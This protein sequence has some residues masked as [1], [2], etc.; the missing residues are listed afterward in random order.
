LDLHELLF[1]AL[2][3]RAD[4]DSGAVEALAARFPEH[5]EALRAHLRTLESAGLVD[6]D[7]A[8]KDPI[9]ER[10]GAFHLRR[11][12]GQGGMGVVYLADDP[13]LGRQVALK[14][15][16]PEQVHFDSARERFRREALSVARLAH[17][18][19]VPLYTAGAAAGLPYF[20]M[21]LVEGASLADTLRELEGRDPS[22]LTGRDLLVAV[23]AVTARRG[24]SGPPERAGDPLYASTWLHAVL[25][26]V[27][28]VAQALEHAHQRGVLHRDIKPSNVLLTADGRVLL[29]D[30]GLAVL[31][32]VDRLTR[33]GAMLGSLPYMSPEQV[34]GAAAD[35]DGRSD[36]YGLGVLLYELLTLKLPF[37]ESDPT[38]LSLRISRG[39]AA[40]PRQLNRALSS[41]VATVCRTAMEVDRARRYASPADLARDLSNLLEHRP[42]QARASGLGLLLVR[43]AQRRPAHAVGV[44][45]LG[46]A[47]VA[48]P[49]TVAGLERRNSVRVAA[50]RDVASRNLDAALEA[51]EV[52]LERVGHNELRDVPGL[53]RLR[54]TLLTRATDL[55]GRLEATTPGDLRT[56]VR[57]A[58]A[59][60]R[61]ARLHSESGDRPAALAAFDAAEAR[62]RALHAEAPDDPALLFEYGNLLAFATVTRFPAD[63]P[64]AVQA[65]QR[66]V[67]LLRRARALDPEALRPRMELARALLGLAHFLDAQREQQAALKAY[68]E[69]EA[70][71]AALLGE[72]PALGPLWIDAVELECTALGRRG[73]VH[74]RIGE[75]DAALALF[76]RILV[77]CSELPKLSGFMRHLRAAT[78]QTMALAL[79]D[80]SA[81]QGSHP[82]LDELLA[83]AHADAVSLARDFPNN[84]RYVSSLLQSHLGLARRARARKDGAR[85][86]SEVSAALRI[87]Q[88][89]VAR[90]PEDPHHLRTLGVSHKLAADLA[91]D[92]GD[93]ASEGAACLSACEAHGAASARGVRLERGDLIEPA[94][95]AME[96][97]LELR[98]FE[99]LCRVATELEVWLPEHFEA[100]MDSA[101]GRMLA[102]ALAAELGAEDEVEGC[103]DAAAAALA[104]ALKLRPEACGLVTEL[105]RELQLAGHP[106]LE[107]DE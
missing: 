61:L 76:Q 13:A 4:G 88:D 43:W 75:R 84:Q 106:A 25:W 48:G 97:A 58:A 56:R 44:A 26:L 57:I 37:P 49:L 19:I 53:E 7:P 5:A 99:L 91:G 29:V 9:P 93:A 74:W 63:P 64:A 28:E 12:I 1:D 70:V 102:V 24:F 71:T 78:V 82:E 54:E 81:S 14:V 34:S 38:Q 40:S 87:G 66:A 104:R 95:R 52:L 30:F 86:A 89:L 79:G 77:R 59:S 41:D 50:E 10:L 100:L 31:Q 73:N 47:L 80:A 72:L 15:L 60:G 35:V 36:V 23:Q 65:L 101:R 45:A 51:I 42:I 103:R 33:T 16:R 6:A 107:R 92:A 94:R 83:L 46:L 32:S 90:F 98:D 21:E 96:L 69:V 3:R 39:D 27:R 11:R 67:E 85:A 105:A 22:Q 2:E 20:S 62:F 55:Y 18:G 17:P 8:R 68:D